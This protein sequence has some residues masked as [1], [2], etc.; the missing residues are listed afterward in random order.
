MNYRENEEFEGFSPPDSYALNE[1]KKIFMGYM[2]GFC[3]AMGTESLYNRNWEIIHKEEITC[4]IVSF[5]LYVRLL[6]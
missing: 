5:Q 6:S 4:A 3:L 1:R 2:R